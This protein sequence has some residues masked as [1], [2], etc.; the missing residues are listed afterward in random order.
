M[1]REQ[2]YSYLHALTSPYS[3]DYFCSSPHLGNTSKENILNNSFTPYLFLSQKEIS[4]TVTS[5]SHVPHSWV[6]R[7]HVPFF[8][9]LRFL[10]KDQTSSLFLYDMCVSYTRIK[11]CTLLDSPF[12]HKWICEAGLPKTSRQ[13]PS[14]APW[15]SPYKLSYSNRSIQYQENGRSQIPISLLKLLQILLNS[16]TYRT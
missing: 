5:I 13:V 14:W 10:G 7:K 9:T 15:N 2:H 4:E 6:D 1:C 16:G 12:Y 8:L 11:T 3:P